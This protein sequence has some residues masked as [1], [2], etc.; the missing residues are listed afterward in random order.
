MKKVKYLF[1]S[2][3]TIGIFM[4]TSCALFSNNTSGNISTSGNI[5]TSGSSEAT[6]GGT[7]TQGA[8]SE[9]T[10]GTT[11]GGA[12]SSEG[13]S[14][15]GSSSQATSTEAQQTSTS[16]ETSAT[17]PV[18]KV[19]VIFYNGTSIYTTVEVNVNS[20]V[21]LPASPTK[22][23]H[24]FLNWCT[25]QGLSSDFNTNTLIQTETKLYANFSVN[26]YQVTFKDGTD[27][28][29][30]KT[31]NYNNEVELFTPTKT[32][33]DFGGW[34]TDSGLTT[35][36]VSTTKITEP[37]TLYAKFTIKTFQVTV[38]DGSST[39]ATVNVNYN[40]SPN[41]DA[42]PTKSGYQFTGY[43]TD[44]GLSSPFDTT[45]KITDNTT[46]YVG[47]VDASS[48]TT[49]VFVDEVGDGAPDL[50]KAIGYT[51]TVSDLPVL[52]KS[53]YSFDGWC[54]DT[55]R[56]TL[57][58]SQ[59]LTSEP[60]T[61]YA[62]WSEAIPVTKV[63]G[64]NEVAYILFTYDEDATYEA[65]YK[66]ASQSAYTNVASEL[67][68]HDSTSGRID[69]LEL[70]P[71]SYDF[72]LT[73][74]K[75]NKESYYNGSFEV[76]AQDRSGYA[77]NNYTDGVG[78]YNDDGTLKDGADIIYVS[79]ATKNT[80]TYNGKTGIVQILANLKNSSN[81]V[82][83]RFL[84]MVKTTQ[85]D[86]KTY[87]SYSSSAILADY[88]D[89]E[90]KD[91]KYYIDKLLKAGANTIDTDLAAG[92]TT[93]DGL[94]KFSYGT[95]SDSY[96]N[97]CN[98]QNASNI[99]IEGVGENAGLFQWG[100][101]WM[102]CSKIEIK[103][104]LFDKY[105]EDACS[106]EGST[107]S[108]TLDDYA[109]IGRY[110]V[111]N[112]TFTQGLNRWDV[113]DDQDKH[114]GDGATDF[115]RTG[116]I[117]L[118]YNHYIENHKTGLIGSDDGTYTANVTFHHNYYEGCNSRMPL[119]RN[120]NMH[121][122]N[123][124]YYGS[125]G[126][127][128]SIR[129]RGYAFVENSVFENCKNPVECKQGTK[130][131]K[132][133]SVVYD[134]TAYT[135]KVKSY[136]NTFTNCTGSNNA[137]IVTDREDTVSNS[138]SYG[139]T[140]DKDS[141]IFYYDSENHRSNV[142]VLNDTADV[143]AYVLATAGAGAGFY[144]VDESNLEKHTVT[145]NFID[146]NNNTISQSITKQVVDGNSAPALAP[147][148]T[149][150]S[151]KGYYTTSGS[152]YSITTPITTDT[153]I[154]VVYQAKEA[155]TVTFVSYVNNIEEIID[156]VTV[157]EGDTVTRPTTDP[158]KDGYTFDDW[159]TSSSFTDK[160]DFT[161]VITAETII[162]ANFN[163]YVPGGTVL[164][165]SDD[166]SASSGV[167]FSAGDVTVTLSGGANLV[168]KAATSGDGKYTFTHAV[169]P[170]GG[171]KTFTI[172]STKNQTIVIYYTITNS[173]WAD[174]NAQM[175]KDGV[176]V[177]SY[178]SSNKCPGATPVAYELALTA[179]TDVVLSSSSR[180]VIWGYENMKILH[181]LKQILIHNLI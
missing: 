3:M 82:C 133:G 131:E 28:L 64:V 74:T 166:S 176:E 15:Q 72:K 85:W 135:G 114:E 17:T 8:T 78:A 180:L 160:F 10:Q 30:T 93:L 91:G 61:L 26:T 12:T 57:F 20:K 56:N 89:A 50:S 151:F 19:N 66:L 32:G 6:Q 92:I 136:N 104:L 123:N 27:V 178:S 140:F 107:D 167:I 175:T 81:P 21:T 99:T 101:N 122:Y 164:V 18:S 48:V 69:I 1:I 83:I 11:T 124:Y 116:N 129:A 100:L 174:Q 130:K 155:F 146:E 94:E 7:S 159:Y 80:V 53:G 40:E 98:I 35:S 118:S 109:E 106:F 149:G 111:H 126:T 95:S 2:V 172:R 115:K 120:A 163:E 145:Y 161:E 43:Y 54:T 125:T 55:A 29:D 44:P 46:I 4:L 79:D 128:M 84:D 148:I 170:S 168:E 177:T 143:K 52:E 154:N 97:M 23:G 67:I 147:S 158:T 36:F 86:S 14:T 60:L 102:N 179:N 113:S 13:S 45:T 105:T 49:V 41:L 153:T 90:I 144:Y 150:Y 173:S 171:G 96:W 73:K 103:N 117:T 24:E 76:Y 181:L 152:S 63:Q 108:E 141:S 162:Y 9:A 34:Y 127:N 71:G 77:H 16:T 165:K 137:T 156:T 62:K 33:Y 42:N 58:T 25:D 65:S 59:V 157:Y 132:N 138:C 75:D 68:R 88:G 5:N 51:L 87:S 110:W 22:E 37:T 47:F 139:T 134:M 142:S 169:L 70:T 121:M 112:N 31:V 38:M 39:F 119:G